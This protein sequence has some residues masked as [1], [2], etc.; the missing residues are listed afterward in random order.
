MNVKVFSSVRF[1]HMLSNPPCKT[2]LQVKEPLYTVCYKISK[3]VTFLT[4]YCKVSCY[5]IHLCGSA[6]IKMV[7]VQIWM[8]GVTVTYGQLLHGFRNLCTLLNQIILY[9]V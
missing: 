2:E 3:L 8:H 9:L 1:Q 5:F 4:F 7:C 6:Q